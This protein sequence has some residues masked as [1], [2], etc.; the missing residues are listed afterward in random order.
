M[1]KNAWR[2]VLTALA[3]NAMLLGGFCFAVRHGIDAQVA[4][5]FGSLCFFTCA[6]AVGQAAKSATEHVANSKV[7]T[8]PQTTAT[9]EEEKK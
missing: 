9:I 2:T 6:I 7:V 8:P 4:A 5:A 1:K 3:S